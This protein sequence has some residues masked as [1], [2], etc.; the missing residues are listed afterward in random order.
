MEAVSTHTSSEICKSFSVHTLCCESLKVVRWTRCTFYCTVLV[1]Y[2][3]SYIYIYMKVYLPLIFSGL[4]KICLHWQKHKKIMLYSLLIKSRSLPGI[5][6]DYTQFHGKWQVADSIHH[7]ATSLCL[8]L[9]PTLHCLV[10][11]HICV[12]HLTATRNSV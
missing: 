7:P 11:S 6:V 5:Q 12:W 2:T 9:C 3:P 8:W 4:Y 1:K 10:F